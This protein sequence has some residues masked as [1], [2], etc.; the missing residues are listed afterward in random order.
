[1]CKKG[2]PSLK[3]YWIDTIIKASGIF[4]ALCIRPQLDGSG[5]FWGVLFRAD[6]YAR[7]FS[8]TDHSLPA[9]V[10]AFWVFGHADTIKIN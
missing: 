4:L 1:M 6:L 7:L 5:I 3:A 8:N 10:K 9:N 2:V